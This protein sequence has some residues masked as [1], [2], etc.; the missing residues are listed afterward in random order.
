M[1]SAGGSR[2]LVVMKFGRTS[3]ED[4]AATRQ[5]IEVVKRRRDRQLPPVVVVS[6]LARVT[7]DLIAAAQMAVT[8]QVSLALASTAGLGIKTSYYED[9]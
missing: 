2:P 3:V 6:A 8:G 5:L 1:D 4:A 7:D 9:L